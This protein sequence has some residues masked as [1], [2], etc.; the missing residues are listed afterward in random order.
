MDSIGGGDEPEGKPIY[1]CNC[2]HLQEHLPLI[3]GPERNGSRSPMLQAASG[4]S[5]PK[6]LKNALAPVPTESELS[7]LEQRRKNME[8]PKDPLAQVW[9]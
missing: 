8:Q 5:K 1:C 7:T 4:S 2:P 9:S 6:N 3:S